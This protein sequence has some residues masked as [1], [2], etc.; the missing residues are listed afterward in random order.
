MTSP[1]LFRG[2]ASEVKGFT[3]V[4]VMVVVTI[5]GVM[6]AIAF[7]YFGGMIAEERVRSAA[8]DLMSDLVSARIEAIKQQR[9]VVMERTGATWNEGWQV[10]VDTNA[11]TT[12]DAGEPVI[13]TSAGFRYGRMKGCSISAAYAAR[14]V[15]RGDGSVLNAP[16]GGAESGLRISDDRERRSRDIRLSPLG[17]ASVDV[18]RE[19]EG[20]VC[21]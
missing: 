18:Y 17:R 8:S 2:H 3:L 15:F 5:L 10:F 1:L 4:E 12:W 11:N 14:V 19:G 6:A 16:I 13:K 9:R 20:S 7:P 21:P